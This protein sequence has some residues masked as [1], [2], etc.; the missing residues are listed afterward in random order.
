ITT[1][2]ALLRGGEP[3]V[4]AYYDGIDKVA[5]EYG[6]GENYDDE[7]VAVD[8]VVSDLAGLLP[9]GA[10]LVVT[11][12]HGQV[13][14]GD[15]IVAIDDEVRELTSLLSGEGRFRWLHARPGMQ[16]RLAKAAR[17]A[18]GPQAWVRPRDAA[19]RDDWFRR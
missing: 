3:F 2:R 7:L 6:V 18:H 4:Y 10:A 1:V 8:R 13:D 17:E 12:D 14:V 11:S 16:D 19:V 9:A 15:R 5:H